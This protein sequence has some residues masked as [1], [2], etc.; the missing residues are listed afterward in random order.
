M[1][2]GPMGS[3]GLSPTAAVHRTRPAVMPAT[4]T[5]A[6]RAMAASR[7]RRTRVARSGRL[8]RDGAGRV[9]GWWPGSRWGVGSGQ[10][11]GSSC[12]TWMATM[13]PSLLAGC[14]VFAW[15]RLPRGAGGAFA[16]PRLAAVAAPGLDCRLRVD[17][18]RRT[19]PCASPCASPRP[20]LRTPVRRDSTTNTRS[21]S[22]PAVDQHPGQ[23]HEQ[24]HG[25]DDGRPAGRALRRV[26]ACGRRQQVAPVEET[27]D[28]GDADQ[29]EPAPGRSD[30]HAVDECHEDRTHVAHLLLRAPPRA[31]PE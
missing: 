25:P 10:I 26:V 29:R 14:D 9:R 24:E 11:S 16:T 3:A 2:D 5:R 6:A 1:G 15:W 13:S 19:A 18:R 22:T 8:R 21:A 7:R 31:T 4:T 20:A 30:E 12:G 17:T 28:G 27:G 23:P